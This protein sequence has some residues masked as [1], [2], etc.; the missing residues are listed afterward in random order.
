[1]QI[2]TIYK[3][4]N[5]DP[6]EFA[7]YIPESFSF[8]AAIFNVFWFA[9]HRV[10]RGLFLFALLILLILEL[11]NLDILAFST[12]ILLLLGVC[13]F[14]G[15]SAY[16]LLRSHLESNGYHLIDVIIASSEDE[17]ECKY[18]Q[19]YISYEYGHPKN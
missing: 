8:K 2:Y 11:T 10:W 12:A 18:L 1:M 4:K 7:V 14:T 13:I 17:A 5:S 9:Y 16:D 3:H 19:K 15:Y 6:T